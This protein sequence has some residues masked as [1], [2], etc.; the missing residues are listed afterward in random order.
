MLKCLLQAPGNTANTT[1][2]N[3]NTIYF[4][5]GNNFFQGGRDKQ[6]IHNWQFAYVKLPLFH[7]NISLATQ[8]QDLP[9]CDAGQ[10]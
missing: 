6:L 8:L 1:I 9:F 4:Y 7:L 3:L 5:D 10:N 2:S